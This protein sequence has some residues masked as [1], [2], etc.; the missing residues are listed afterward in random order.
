[1]FSDDQVNGLQL[2]VSI[3]YGV[4]YLAARGGGFG[5]AL[6]VFILQGLEGDDLGTFAK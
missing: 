6:D 4:G 5:A 1:L 3:G 2:V